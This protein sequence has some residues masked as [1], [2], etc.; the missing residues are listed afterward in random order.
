MHQAKTKTLSEMK[1]QK[2]KVSDGLIKNAIK[3]DLIIVNFVMP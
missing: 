1:R 3:I 2:C